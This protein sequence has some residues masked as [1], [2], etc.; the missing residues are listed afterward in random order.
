MR[1]RRIIY[2]E[3]VSFR[4]IDPVFYTSAA[5]NA[6]ALGDVVAVAVQGRAA[7]I[8]YKALRKLDEKQPARGPS[9]QLTD[10]P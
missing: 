5:F 1:A 7:S 6:V 10:I 4:T 3:P 2:Q 8:N 9:R